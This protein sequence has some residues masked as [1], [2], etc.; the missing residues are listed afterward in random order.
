LEDSNCSLVIS[1][2]FHFS[3]CQIKLCPFDGSIEGFDMENSVS[4]AAQE[5]LLDKMNSELL[6]RAKLNPE[7]VR[8]TVGHI[9]EAV[10]RKVI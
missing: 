10:E 7:F 5:E 9:Y 1:L 4:D 3:K 2:F 6:R 8:N